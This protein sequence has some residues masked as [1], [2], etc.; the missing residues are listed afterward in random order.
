MKKKGFTLIE[1][2]VVITIIGVLA[3]VLVPA[4]M[5]W[6]KKAKIQAANSTASEAMKSINA[7]I[8]DDAQQDSFAKF[9][10]GNYGFNTNVGTSLETVADDENKS[11]ADYIVTYSDGLANEN[12]AI[13]VK[14]GIVVAAAAKNG[15]FFGTYPAFL[16]GTNYEKT[17]TVKTMQGALNLAKEK[18]GYVS[19]EDKAEGKED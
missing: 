13:Y 1:L 19:E 8:G 7:I 12:F 17:L 6:I 16:T 11:L 18:A 15:K 9:E 14:D 4:M 2:I 5:G 10:E 3:A